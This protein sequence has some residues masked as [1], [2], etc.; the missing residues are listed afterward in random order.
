MLIHDVHEI[1][2]CASLPHA[3]GWHERKKRK[4]EK[5]EKERERR[6]REG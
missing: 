3:V 6:E 1:V 5:E 2:L 4:R